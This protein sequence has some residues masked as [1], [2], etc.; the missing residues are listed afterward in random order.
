MPLKDFIAEVMDILRTSP[1]ASEIC[2]ERVKPLRFA[3]RDGAYD[4]TF[5]QFNDSVV[6][7]HPEFAHS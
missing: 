7:A 2:V 3:E 6:L 5:K 4:G 1:D